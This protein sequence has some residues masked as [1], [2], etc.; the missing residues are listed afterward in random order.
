M[1]SV[2]DKITLKFLLS[3]S[4]EELKKFIL[5]LPLD[6]ALTCLECL[7]E[8]EIKFSKNRKDEH[9]TKNNLINF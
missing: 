9:L 8:Y 1:N 6:E 2:L 5:D 3:L 7:K 4:N